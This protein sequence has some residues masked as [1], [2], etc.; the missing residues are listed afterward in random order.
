MAPRSRLA[1]TALGAGAV[2]A[3]PSAVF[4]ST[5]VVR[6]GDSI[7]D[8]AT[9]HGTTVAALERANDTTAGS[10]R[11]GQLLTIPDHRVALPA[12]ARDAD[13]VE[14][15]VTRPGEGVLEIA[16]HYGA[17]PTAL[18]R[19]NGVN[20]NAPLREGVEL[21]VPGRLARMN[22]LLEDVAAGAAVDAALVRAVG[23]VESTWRQQLVSPTGAV[24]VMQLEPAAGDWV[25]RKL[26]GRRLNIWLARDNVLAGT[27][28]LGHLLETH[29]GDRDA[30]LAA[31]YQGGASVSAGGVFEDTSRYVRSVRDA[32]SQDD[33]EETSRLARAP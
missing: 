24:G 16:R 11:V 8:I 12:Y 22:A 31:Y 15:H 28:L 17:D 19:F 30:A 6:P 29:R 1:V 27:L 23:W 5:Y 13:D 21:N 26:A 20:V 25:S 32:M 3:I 10:L 14:T 33:R 4:A 2:A 7:N 9:R 18:A